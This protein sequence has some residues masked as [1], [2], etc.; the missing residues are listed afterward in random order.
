MIKVKSEKVIIFISGIFICG[1]VGWLFYDKLI[2]GIIISVP[3][4]YLI[5]KLY[6]GHK[7]KNWKKEFERQFEDALS[8]LVSALQ[9]G[10]SLE[11]SLF[12]ITKQLL[13]IYGK[14]G[15]ILNELHVICRG[16]S[17]NIPVEK[18]IN[19]MAVRTGVSAVSEFA[20]VLVIAKKK[21]R[22]PYRCNKTAR[23][24]IT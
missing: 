5:K 16:L 24:Y 3:S 23:K 9:A 13:L 17:V 19:D 12:E 10:Y 2:F 7:Q 4:Y 20:E 14:D 11:N 8:C 15:Y 6:A 21:R 1:F 22:Q 18:L